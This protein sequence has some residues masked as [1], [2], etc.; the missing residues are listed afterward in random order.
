MVI[1]HVLLIRIGDIKRQNFSPK[2]DTDQKR[3]AYCQLPHGLKYK[4]FVELSLLHRGAG[5]SATIYNT[6]TITA[7][8]NF[9]L[10]IDAA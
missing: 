7:G 6:S 10:R 8:Q 9:H 4:Q 1:F 3:G 5:C 2:G